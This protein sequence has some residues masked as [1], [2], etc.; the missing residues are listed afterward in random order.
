MFIAALFVGPAIGMAFAYL[1]WRSLSAP[2]WARVLAVL[3]VMLLLAVLPLP[4][5]EGRLGIDAG[6]LGGVL[7]WLTAPVIADTDSSTTLVEENAP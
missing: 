1:L 6:L 3:V 2:P 4:A 5:L 7:L